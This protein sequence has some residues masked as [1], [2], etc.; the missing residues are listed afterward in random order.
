MSTKRYWDKWITASVYKHFNDNITTVPIFFTHV[1][2]ETASA[3]GHSIVS[4]KQ[5]EAELLEVR[6]DGPWL[7]VEG[8]TDWTARVELNILVQRNLRG[9]N[10][11]RFNELLGLVTDNM[12][13]VPVYKYGSE[14]ADDETFVGCLTISGTGRRGSGIEI[15]KFGR[16][17]KT[18]PLVQGTVEAHY[19]ITLEET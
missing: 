18:I 4:K 3:L 15:N 1:F 19:E 10:I 13:K 11:Y 14:T 8:K 5:D 17:D 16:I 2:A 7:Y 9:S 12:T 6:M